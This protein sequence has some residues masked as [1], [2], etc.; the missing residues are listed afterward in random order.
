MS[1]RFKVVLIAN[2]DHPIPDWVEERFAAAEINYV[3]HQCYDRRDLEECA[4]DADVLWLMSS[5]EGLVVEENMDIFKRAGVA[6]KCGSGTDNIDHEACTKRGIIVAHTPED[7]VEPVSDHFIALLFGTMRQTTRQDRLVRQG[8]CN[9]AAA[10]PIGHSAGADLGL[11]GFGR[12]GKTVARKL[13]GFHMHIRVFDPY[14]DASTIEKAGASKAGLQELLQKSQFV[15]LACPLTQETRGL[16]GED[17]LRTMRSDA[18]LI[19]CA[20]GGVVVEEALVKALSEDWIKAAALDV[21]EN[22]PEKDS[23]LLSLE[24]L[25][26]TPHMGGTPDT[27]PEGGFESSVD[28]IIE[29]SKMH[30]PKWVANKGV[31]PKWQMKRKGEVDHAQ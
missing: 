7:P 17:E 27:Y 16:I 22:V 20:R 24:N 15:L 23:K 18:I 31:K 26:L 5:R 12:I 29:I 14:L 21:F 1:D 9:P 13:S 28:V 8:V 3:Y 6:I 19:N 11:I 25:T 2:D 10:L 4:S 30:W